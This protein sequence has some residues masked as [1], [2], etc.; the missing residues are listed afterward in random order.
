MLW[1]SWAGPFCDKI[2]TST[3]KMYTDD[4]TNHNNLR[5][6]HSGSICLLFCQFVWIG[7][8]YHQLS[9]GTITTNSFFPFPF[10]LP[11]FSSLSASSSSPTT[12][13]F[14]FLQSIVI[15]HH[16]S[17]VSLFILRF[18]KLSFSY[19]FHSNQLPNSVFISVLNGIPT[20]IV[21]D[22]EAH[23]QL[24]RGQ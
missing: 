9:E 23:A 19:I 2:K 21:C 3:V 16:I 17:L 11:S 18:Y 4:V 10:P 1:R 14:F 6:S 8:C 7:W 12:F 13:S 5:S 22:L 24:E 20:I 15:W